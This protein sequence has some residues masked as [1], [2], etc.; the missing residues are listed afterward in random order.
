MNI[1]TPN[2][3]LLLSATVLILAGC[4]SLHNPSPARV[5]ESERA[6][7]TTTSSL[8]L[9]GQS[10]VVA[11]G[12]NPSECMA[13]FADCRI[14]VGDTF[15]NNSKSNLAA[16]AELYYA[17]AKYQSEQDACQT[18]FGRPPLD[19]YYAND[20]SDDLKQQQQNARHACQDRY[21]HS[22]FQALRYSYAYLF[23][24]NLEHTNTSTNIISE[25]HIRTQDIYHISTYRLVNEIYL[26]Q[27]GSFATATIKHHNY[28]EQQGEQLLISSIQTPHANLDIYLAN[29]AYYLNNIDN[30]PTDFLSE[31]SSIY[32]TNLPSLNVT[33]TR[34][35]IGVGY[36]GSLKNRYQANNPNSRH[37][38]LP[39][40]PMGHLLMT[41]VVIPKGTSVSEVI[42]GQH[43]EI[44]F[45][46]PYHSQS[47]EILGQSYPLY[48]NFSSGYA[49][50]LAENPFNRLAVAHMLGKQQEIPMPELFMLEPYNPN[51]KVIIM[52]HG[53][54]SSP[55]TWVELTNSLLAD[56]V[57]RDNYQV[58][59]VFY[60]TNLP[61]LENRYYIYNLINVAFAKVDPA[62]VQPASRN[63]TIIA[64][65]MGAVISRLMLSSDNLQPRLDT[66]SQSDADRR[67]TQLLIQSHNDDLHDRLQLSALPQVD[68]AVFVSAPFRGTDYA[69][70]WFT[71]GL[72]RIISLPVGITA[73]LGN[74][75]AGQEHDGSGSTLGALYLQ[76][77]A[78]QL[79]DKS[80]FMQLTGDI[81]ISPQ[82]RYHSIMANNRRT[83]SDNTDVSSSVSTHISDGIVPYTS[84][85]LEGAASEVIIEGGHSIHENPKTILHLR[86]I[87]HDKLTATH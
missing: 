42:H 61:I 23:Y 38:Q 39:I 14:A 13:A 64:H 62:G 55:Y 22:L 76:N 20:L 86:Q 66:I 26:Q 52:L 3:K 79:S 10:L 15:L 5:I 46:N 82:V 24:D 63:A 70:R 27:Q 34:S 28:R 30:S 51:K 85:H 19:P 29:D 71:R 75:L 67:L 7:I 77:G 8:S 44:F 57:L 6:N 83:H 49:K 43:F 74:A 12:F 45:Y 18:I 36:I 40:Y 68:T 32:D 58:W 47:V 33:S 54:A 48:A 65:S 9:A 35:G 53:L 84:S 50:W 69:D 25:E 80:A 56:P 59:Q 17:Q 73:T 41:A 16:L 11:S 78:S 21:L 87:L 60:A 1:C 81:Q 2:C 37:K 72:R 31:L 4:Q